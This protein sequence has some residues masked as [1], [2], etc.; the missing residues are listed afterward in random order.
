MTATVVIGAG[1]NGLT[2]ATLLARKGHKVV[3]LEAA[4]AVGGIAAPVEF[5]PGYRSAGVLHDTGGLRPRAVSQLA[6][7]QHGLKL[8][9]RRPDVLALG[10]DQ[11][12]S[13]PGDDDPARV[14]AALGGDADGYLRY[15]AALDRMRPVLAS[16]LDLPP[17]DVVRVET[18]SRW[19]LL[20]RAMK[21]RRLGRRDMLELLRL[22]PMCVADWLGEFMSGAPLKAA[23]A[24]PAVAGDFLGPW[25]P[26]GAVAIAS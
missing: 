4:D 23:L 21:V 24:W 9:P 15:R 26:S 17:V 22:P 20:K 12:I 8:R 6:L 11:R 1:L 16:F 5:H 10:G 25:S 14:R 13:I 7:E 19:E 2:C 18:V 3:L